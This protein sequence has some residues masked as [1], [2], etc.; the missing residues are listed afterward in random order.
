MELLYFVI[1]ICLN[2]TCQVFWPHQHLQHQTIMKIMEE[3]DVGADH[4]VAIED[5]LIILNSREN[6]HGKKNGS[7]IGKN[8]VGSGYI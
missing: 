5:T 7:I 1:L 2:L 8:N 6:N 4:Y 3:G